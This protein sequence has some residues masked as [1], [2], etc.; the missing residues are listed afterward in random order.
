MIFK[1]FRFGMLLQL[2]IGPMCL[3]VFNTS[4]SSGLINGL[5]LMSA[6]ALIDFLFIVLSAL[7]VGA[8]LDRKNIRIFI[9]I[10][11]GVVLIFFGADMIA[12]AFGHSIIPNI[13]LFRNVKTDSIFITGLLLTASNPLTIVFWSGVFSSQVAENNYTKKQLRFFGAGC[14]LSTIIFLSLVAVIGTVLKSFVSQTFINI[15]N[16]CVGVFIIIYAI[17]MLLKKQKEKTT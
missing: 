14:V 8:F 2:A 4:A 15:L 7:G 10:F 13:N 3:L 16:G 5:V 17:K 12:G 1:G 6:V 9:K 11:G